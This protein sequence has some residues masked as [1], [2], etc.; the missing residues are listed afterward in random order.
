MTTHTATTDTTAGSTSPIGTTSTAATAAR[1]AVRRV[2]ALTAA[3]VRLLLRNRTTLV[4]GLVVPVLPLLLLV[5]ADGG[6]PGPGAAV[7]SMT[8]TMAL[9][10]PVYYNLLSMVVTR[11]DEL[12]LKRYRTGECRDRELLASMALP[13]AVVALAA[14]V[15]AWTGLLVLGADLP[16]N[17]V[18]VLGA[19]LLGVPM[20]CALALWTAAWTRTA[21]SAQ[22]TSLPALVLLAAGQ[23]AVA[24]PDGVRQV[25]DLTPGSALVQLQRIGWFGL[26]EQAQSPTL[27]LASSW[28]VAVQPVVV[29]LVWTVGALWVA[30]RSMRW[31]PRS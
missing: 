10:F 3:N 6:A 2:R 7:L 9:G 24:A 26:E 12:V 19:V 22:L 28:G 29:L 20:A 17:P 27:D 23:L 16:V 25:L 4:Y 8:L 13:G 30:R 18:L 11:R 1:D 5:G 15:L 21:E 31:E 14:M